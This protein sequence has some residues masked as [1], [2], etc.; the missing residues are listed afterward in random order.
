[1][2]KRDYYEVLGVERDAADREIAKA[3]R[4][5]AVKFHPD[6]NPGDE[7]ASQN[8]KEA[9]EAYEV[10]S[11]Q[12][13]R[14]RYDR[15]G[16]AGVNGGSQF[17]SAEDIFA[18]FGE[19]FGGGGGGGMFGDLFGGGGSRSRRGNDVRANVTLTLEEA[20][21]GVNKTLKFKRNQSCEPCD[22]SGSKPGSQPEHCQQCGGRGQVL[23]SAGI[24]RVQT[25]CPVCR[26]AGQII[27]DP[28]GS[29]R[30]QGQVSKT[31]EL[32]VAIPAGVDDGMRV[33]LSGEGESST[34]GG[35]PG[36]CYVFITVKQHKLFHRD[37]ENLILQMPISYTQAALGAEIEVPTLT[38]RDKFKIT[39]GTQ[40]GEV[41]KLPGRGM[42]NP[43]GGRTGDLLVQTYIETPKKIS[44]EQ[45]ELLRKLAE[46]EETEVLPERKNFLQRLT[47]YFSAE[48]S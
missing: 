41:F 17:G 46:L 1:M 16:H 32:D 24:L 3:Y 43:Q 33:R 22:G 44:T 40:S 29:C 35:P 13:K 30:G 7:E 20:A 45:E 6:S 23:Q 15:H 9:A 18:A 5:L 12:E 26:G 10:L 34:S 4:K 28:C 2:A 37:S 39:P 11:D 14:G 27:V 36:D 25:T 47:D 19:M 48:E 21:Q 31:V 8:F 42:P 38:G